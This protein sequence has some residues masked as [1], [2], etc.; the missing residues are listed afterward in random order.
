MSNEALVTLSIIAWP[1]ALVIVALIVRPADTR[2]YTDDEHS[3]CVRC[4]APMRV[5][6]DCCQH[7]D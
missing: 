7:S 2:D 4:R 6:A 5:G 3:M 1:L